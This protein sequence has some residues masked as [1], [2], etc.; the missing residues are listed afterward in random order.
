[1]NIRWTNYRHS[2]SRD[3][4]LGPNLGA[5]SV[6]SNS[7]PGMTQTTNNVTPD[8]YCLKI[9][10]EQT[11][12]TAGELH[13]I[14]SEHLERGVDVALDL[15]EV[16]Q[17]DA[18]ALQLICASRQSAAQR[19]RAFEVTAVSPAVVEAAAGIGLRLRNPEAEDPQSEL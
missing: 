17:C 5:T 14:L 10:G 9:T 11:I 18:A 6:E 16:H 4:R 12:R 1:M 19:N 8:L 13:G 15:S 3:S 7:L 2:S